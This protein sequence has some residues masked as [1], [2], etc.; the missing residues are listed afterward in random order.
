VKEKLQKARVGWERMFGSR[1]ATLT[2]RE[3]IQLKEKAVL[4]KGGIGIVHETMVDGV[5]VAWKR[6]WVRSLNDWNPNEVQILRRMSEKRHQ[7]IIELVGSYTTP[8]YRG[9]HEIAISIWPVALCDL[10]GLLHHMDLL[11]AWNSRV[12]A[13][14]SSESGSLGPLTRNMPTDEEMTAMDN[15]IELGQLGTSCKRTPDGFAVWEVCCIL[16]F[17]KARLRCAVGCIAEALRFLH[18]NDIRHKDIKPSQILLTQRGLRLSDFGWS[19]DIS[20]LTSSMTSNGDTITPRY[21]APE[22]QAKEKCGRPEDIFSL[23]C[24]YLEMGYRACGL[25]PAHY[26]NPNNDK[27]WSFQAHLEDINNWL[28]PLRLKKGRRRCPWRTIRSMLAKDPENRPCIDEVI[29]TLTEEKTRRGVGYFAKCCVPSKLYEHETVCNWLTKTAM[30]NSLDSSPANILNSTPLSEERLREH[31][32]KLQEANDRTDTCEKAKA[33]SNDSA[34]KDLLNDQQTDV[35]DHWM[36]QNEEFYRREME[37]IVEEVEKDNQNDT[38]LNLET[39]LKSTA[40]KE[41]LDNFITIPGPSI[42]DRKMYAIHAD[43]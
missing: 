42:P 38:K 12:I 24:T 6:T 31:D 2:S 27:Q 41:I 4:G 20:H 39:P 7:H 3:T 36:R 8:S 32:H 19:Q 16:D 10:S 37:L 13:R 23:G 30:R 18:R 14:E 15:L 29:R 34:L 22:R 21:H 28:K 40:S 33:A 9:M 35:L 11:H 17:T 43:S 26:L 5:A 25:D 1:H